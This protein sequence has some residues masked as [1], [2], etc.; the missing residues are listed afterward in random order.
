V[1]VR[2]ADLLDGVRTDQSAVFDGEGLVSELRGELDVA[3]RAAV[4]GV[5]ADLLPIRAPKDRISKVLACERLAVSA[6][7][8]GA[9][10]EPVVRGRILDRLLHHHVHGDG[11]VGGPALAIAEGAFDA[12]RD[13][14]LV[15]WLSTRLDERARLA[16]DASEFA[17]RL[18]EWGT[19]DSS[20]WPRCEDRVRVDLAE[21]RLVCSAQIDLVAGGLPT[22]LPMV[23]VEAKSGRF[24]QDH[25]EGLFWYAL[26]AALRHG[27]P[28][29]AVIGW[30]AW[31]G[32][33]WCQAV[34][35]GLLRGAAQRGAAAFA[36]LGNLAR[37]GAPQR[38]ACRACAW[39]PERSTCSAAV[40]PEERDDDW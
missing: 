7:E 38:S 17:T 25:R 18:R 1:T 6:A 36:R 31:D 29:A 9:L 30:S 24:G 2:L 21:A 13:D 14:E 26:L 19:I 32:A 3:A 22:D 33:G 12:E 15:D 28:P 20:W 16:A 27:R 37:G 23:L 4:E 11:P 39:C 5:D 8:H 35:E 40:V 10:S 34:T